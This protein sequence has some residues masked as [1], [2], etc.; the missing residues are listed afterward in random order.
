VGAPQTRIALL[1]RSLA[2]AGADVAVH[3]GF[4]HYP[5]GTIT[6]PYRNRPWAV[7]A[8]DGVRVVRSAVYAAA[9]RGFA[10]RLL[11][12]SAFA[13]SALATMRLTGPLDVVVA[14]T[15]PLFTA[16]AS[17]P[18]ARVKR[19][20][21]VTHVADRWPA[22]AVEL[23]ALTSTRAIAAA[24]ALERWIYRGSERVVAPTAG[25]VDALEALPAAAGRVRRVWPVVDLDRFALPAADCGPGPLR[26][27]YAGTL[28]LAHGLDVLVEATR[29]AGPAVVQTTIAGDGAERDR[30]LRLARDHAVENVSLPG[31]LPADAV[32]ALYRRAD[33]AAVLLRDL[34]I[35]AGA[36]PTK[37]LEGMASGRPLLLSARGEAARMV[38]E[39]GA[40]LVVAPGDPE[41]L[42]D[43]IGRL[44]REPE[45]R[46]ALGRA[47]RRWAE[48][49]F[50]AAR[51]VAQWSAILA[52]AAG[53]RS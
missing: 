8:R 48:E 21:L 24:E 22:S 53:L 13:A 23:G 39:A 43:A 15:P 44:Q 2:A 47:G 36:L 45:L 12:H 20:A 46:D 34:P 26:L 32:P 28:G 1:A 50:G 38:A 52:E 49:H 7:E 51:S 31:A 11:D 3:T 25:I 40:G 33:A 6:P 4:P 17:V 42:A 10:R 5:G 16:A 14:E 29:R 35:F 41:A 19:A 37:L 18:Y 9:N 27:L 30:L